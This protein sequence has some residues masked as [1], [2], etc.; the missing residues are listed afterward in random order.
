MIALIAINYRGEGKAS[1]IFLDAN[2]KIVRDMP[3]SPERMADYIGAGFSTTAET[4][5]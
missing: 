4:T 3:I 1:I 5:F 2:N